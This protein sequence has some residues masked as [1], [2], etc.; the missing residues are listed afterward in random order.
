MALRGLIAR[1][2]ARP[3]GRATGST[4]GGRCHIR[5]GVGVGDYPK[6]MA[7]IVYVTGDID[8]AKTVMATNNSCGCPVYREDLPISEWMC[9]H[10][11]YWCA[12]R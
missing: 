2:H 11:N 6:H 12:A 1:P 9:E 5:A 4:P 10:G 3:P 7:D 8:P